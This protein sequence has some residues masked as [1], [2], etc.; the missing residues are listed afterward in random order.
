MFLQLAVIRQQEI[1]REFNESVEK[2][3]NFVNCTFSLSFVVGR[4]SKV[5]YVVP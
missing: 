3:G 2:S 5:F 4:V 1:L